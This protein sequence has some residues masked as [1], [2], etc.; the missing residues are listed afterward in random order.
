VAQPGRQYQPP[1]YVID[2]EAGDTSRL[3]FTDTR[4]SNRDL[5]QFQKQMG[6]SKQQQ[7][8]GP[9]RF[10]GRFVDSAGVRPG[11][12]GNPSAAS[13]TGSVPQGAANPFYLPPRVWQ[14]MT[15]QDQQMLAA[16]WNR[17]SPEQQRRA[18]Q[19]IQKRDSTGAVFQRRPP[20][21]QPPP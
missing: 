13:A 8:L 19:Q 9:Q 2:V 16:R 1:Q 15:P 5:T 7:Q 11:A 17:M 12:P 4:A 20:L 10:G 14:N 6:Q 3:M 18:L 21:R